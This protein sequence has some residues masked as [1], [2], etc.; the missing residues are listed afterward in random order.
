MSS[1]TAVEQD[2]S[3]LHQHLIEIDSG[4]FSF[5]QSH[6]IL[7]LQIQPEEEF[8]RVTDKNS[9]LTWPHMQH[10]I[11]PRLFGKL[12]PGIRNMLTACSE[13]LVV[14]P[15]QVS[16]PKLSI[17]PPFDDGERADYTLTED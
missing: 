9:G 3:A 2:A 12:P 16:S 13:D 8:G 7:M 5:G 17:Q 14:Y 10:S 4:Q 6:L 1:Q 15:G 11:H